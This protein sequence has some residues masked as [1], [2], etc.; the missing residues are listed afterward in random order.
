MV[1]F[2]LLILLLLMGGAVLL[3]VGFVGRVELADPHCRKCK[4]SLRGQLMSGAAPE[5][6]PECGAPLSDRR[7]V[8]FG[9]RKRG[10]ALMVVGAAMLVLPVLVVVIAAAMSVS[11]RSVQSNNALLA[12]LAT[13]ADQPWDWREVESRIRAGSMS[14]AEVDQA[15]DILATY[16]EQRRQQ[17][18]TGPLS[19]Q[20]DFYTLVH[21]SGLIDPAQMDRLAKGFYGPEPTITAH[22]DRRQGQ[23]LSFRLDWGDHWNLPGVKFAKALR[24]VKVGDRELTVRSDERPN[25]DNPDLLSN[26]AV[27]DIEGKVAIDLPPGEY[28]LQFVVDAGLVD[29]QS[30]FVGIDGKPGQIGRWPSPIHTWQAVVTHT[31]TVRPEDAALVGLVTDPALDPVAAGAVAAPTLSVIPRS[32]GRNRVQVE[33]PRVESPVPLSFDV[34]MRAGEREI[35]LGTHSGRQQLPSETEHWL[36]EPLPPEVRTVDLVLTPN[37]QA[38]ER[39]IEVREIWGAP[40]TLEDVPITRGD[41]PA[42]QQ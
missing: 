13:T 18:Q 20:D 29:E 9:T 40:V 28:D 34:V 11:S 2:P 14:H 16:L 35:P 6:C 8:R 12:D 15:I 41:L 33:W 31:L 30:T 4:Y 38:A 24:A 36:R 1:I 5:A 22:P 37:P 27:W 21:S 42:D 17:G 25:Q 19:W 32:D 39:Y 23:D 10:V 26:D 3:A 7:A